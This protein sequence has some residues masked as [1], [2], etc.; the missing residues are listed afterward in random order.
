MPPFQARVIGV[1]RR[2]EEDAASGTQV[3]GDNRFQVAGGFV[4]RN[5]IEGVERIVG[6]EEDDDP[7]GEDED[8][9]EETEGK[10]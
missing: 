3:G 2:A 1:G 8:S 7:Y 4:D 6:P 5:G 10:S 9:E